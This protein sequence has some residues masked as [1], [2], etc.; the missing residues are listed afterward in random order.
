MYKIWA[1]SN[2]PRLSYW[3]LRTFSP[4]N[5]R[6]W[7]TFAEQFWGVRGLNFTNLAEGI[8]RSFIPNKFA[9]EFRYVAAFSTQS[10]VMLK[11]TPNFALF[12]PPLWKLRDGRARSLDQ[13]LKLYLRPN[14]RN[15]FEGHPLR[16]CWA[17][18]IDKK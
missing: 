15:T 1:K 2:N 8:E 17:R 6:E 5:F 13:L 9:L 18:C 11:S 14:L 16:G 10:W 4:C 3:R 7:G 12:A